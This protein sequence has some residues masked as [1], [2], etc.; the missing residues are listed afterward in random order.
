M[1]RVVGTK[2]PDSTYMTNVYNQTGLLA[3]TSGSR[4]YPVAYGYDAQ[5]RMT[6]MTTWTNFTAG[7]GA[8]TTTCNYDPY[9]GFLNSKVYTNGSGPSYTYTPAGRLKTRTWARGT[10]TTNT[11]NPDGGL[12]AVRYSNRTPGVTNGYD[13][14]GRLVS[15]NNGPTVTTVTLNDAGETLR[16]S[17]SG[18]PLNGLSITNRF[19]S[20]LRRINVSILN[21]PSSILA[22]TTYGY[23]AASRLSTVSDGTNSAAY[24]YLAYSP[25]VGQIVFANNGAMQMT[26]TKTYDNLNRLTGIVNGN[27]TIPPVDQRSYAYNSA[28]QRTGMT[29]VD[30]S[31]WVYT[32][33][34]L[35]QA[36]SGIKYWSDGTLVAGQQFDYT[37]D[38]IGN[39]LSTK[40]GGN[41]SG[42]NLCQVNYANYLLNQIASCDAPAYI[43]VMG[44]T[45]ATNIVSVDGFRAYQ[46][47]QYFWQQLPTSNTLA[48]QW[49]GITVTAPGQPTVSGHQLS[50]PRRRSNSSTMTP[51]GT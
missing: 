21:S 30:G 36:T 4:T 19:D 2:L 5:G 35:G 17:Y 28:N 9:R 11:Y 24:S 42:G 32:Y 27:G 48:P 45:L 13:R 37:F 8:A 3:A 47:Y 33:D 46:R 16:E 25:L 26:A 41:A 43:D 51:T 38:T 34:A 40:R 50:R 7:T 6:T 29:N 31:Y 12:A 23:D 44:L 39:R 22:S 20:L 49:V 18:G 14:R 1:G 15:I 10:I